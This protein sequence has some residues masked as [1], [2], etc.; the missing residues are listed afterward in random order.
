MARTKRKPMQLETPPPLRPLW[1]EG[2]TLG[3]INHISYLVDTGM[4]RLRVP[5]EHSKSFF[6]NLNSFC[7]GDIC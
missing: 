4:D 3:D 1:S 5:L 6:V 7:L 2:L